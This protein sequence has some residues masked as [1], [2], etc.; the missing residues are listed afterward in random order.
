MLLDDHI[1]DG[2]C[3]VSHEKTEKTFPGL[4]TP[5]KVFRS[6]LSVPGPYFKRRKL[7]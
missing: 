5:A 2:T 3:K 1:D 4:E 6:Y 7:E